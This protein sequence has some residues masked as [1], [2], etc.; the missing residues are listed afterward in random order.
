MTTWTDRVQTH[1][2]FT[3]LANVESLLEQIEPRMSNVSQPDIAIPD[4]DRIRQV[5]ALTRRLVDSVDP[6][7]API[8][9]LTT[10]QSTM[11]Q[12]KQYLGSF[13]SDPAQISYLQQA[14]T[15]LDPL[16]TVLP[17]FLVVRDEAD[18]R[19]V[20]EALVSLRQSA[21]QN[22]RHATED[23]IRLRTAVSAVQTQV[24]AQE[25][26]LTTQ[27]GRLDQNITTFQQQFSTA[28]ESRNT[29]F[30]AGQTARAS[31]FNSAQVTRAAEFTAAQEARQQAANTQLAEQKERL[32]K[33]V[34][35]QREAATEFL[36]ESVEAREEAD[37]ALTEQ[38]GRLLDAIGDQLK[39]AQK[40][41]GIIGQTGMAAGFQRVANEERAAAEKWNRIAV[42][43]FV[44]L[45]LCAMV[46]FL[47]TMQ[48]DF[49]WRAFAGRAFISLTFGLFAGYAAQQA[50]HHQR[51]ERITRQMELEMASVGPFL[52]PLE[53]KDR[54]E[55]IL[56]LADRMFAQPPVLDAASK[57]D[58]PSSVLIEAMK[59]AGGIYKK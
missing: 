38:A 1:A 58:P 53:E 27:K 57:A 56:K 25:N 12:V 32:D 43:A 34:A 46:I 36:R 37:R 19:G 45:I 51:S 47:P 3:S 4:F 40:V 17:M 55:M 6:N 31:E 44:G 11:E 41:A 15:A 23:V 30:N 10:V 8:S 20:K 21:A 29:E 48:G 52:A 9:G 54:N 7:L 5:T 39:E 16:L 26:E 35:D 22:L 42:I 28:Q 13:N 24:Q 14:N 50:R 33:L 18:A 59:A 49:D 2:A